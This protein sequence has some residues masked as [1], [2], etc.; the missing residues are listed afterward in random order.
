MRQMFVVLAGI[1]LL[2][3]GCNSG[4]VDRLRTELEKARS[5]LQDAEAAERAAEKTAQDSARDR[6]STAKQ[7]EELREELGQG[8]SPGRVWLY[9]SHWLDS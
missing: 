4:E 7:L 9:P 3:S 1:A 6:R 2:A 8:E 5:Q